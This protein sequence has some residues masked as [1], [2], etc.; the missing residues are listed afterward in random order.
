[1]SM[2]PLI[3]PPIMRALTTKEE[4]KPFKSRTFQLIYGAGAKAI[5]KQAGCS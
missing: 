3:Q 5:S 4:R 2:V 1:M